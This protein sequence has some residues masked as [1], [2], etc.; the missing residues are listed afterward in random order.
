MAC[1]GGSDFPGSDAARIDG[2]REMEDAGE[3]DSSSALTD[4]RPEDQGTRLDHGPADAGT[5]LDRGDSCE[6]GLVECCGDQFACGT[7][8][9]GL[10]C[11]GEMG[12]ACATPDGSD[13]CGSA[14]CVGGRCQP[15][16]GPAPRF[17][18][19]FQ[20]GERW[21]YSHH[22]AEVRLALDFVRSDG[23][24]TAGAPVLASAAGVATRHFQAG[25]AGNYVVVEHGDGWRTYYF[26]LSE[27]SVSD[28]A[29]VERGTPVG[30]TGSTGASSG[31]HIHYEQLRGGA[32]Q[33]I[34]L[35]GASLAPYPPTYGSAHWTSET[36]CD[37]PRSFATWGN[38][39]PIH[40]TPSTSSRVLRTIATPTTVSVDCQA[41]GGVVTAEGY[42]NEWWAHVPALGGYL[43][44]IYIAVSES[45]L[46]GVPECL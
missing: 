7:T 21:T 40:E 13:C 5:C 25:G 19:P 23:G 37:G 24:A 45:F 26:H 27:Y 46:P 2:G 9:A 35:E 36:A 44:N 3:R 18:A 34:H 41:R 28:G 42:M 12:A 1:S 33:T 4:A 16:G 20:C 17:A 11:C 8:T 15:P 43:S 32:G 38:D 10:V 22:S 30:R 31:A 6:P 39:R 29:W 14:L